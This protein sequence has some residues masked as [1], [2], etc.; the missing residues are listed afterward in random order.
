MECEERSLR[1][2]VATYNDELVRVSDKLKGLAAL[3]L[4][5]RSDPIAD[6]AD[7]MSGV[8][9][10]L[11]GLSDDLGK[12]YAALDGAILKT[13]GAGSDAASGRGADDQATV[14]RSEPTRRSDSEH[15]PDS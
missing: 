11:E 7:A 5:Q 3:F 1:C 6:H 9:Y 15:R 12:I 10:I 13:A 4:N 8:G 14:V 2:V